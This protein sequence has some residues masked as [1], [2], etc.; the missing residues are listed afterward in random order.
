MALFE[1]FEE[2]PK[3]SEVSMSCLRNTLDSSQM[4]LDRLGLLGELRA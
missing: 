3:C 2:G 4:L 1:E